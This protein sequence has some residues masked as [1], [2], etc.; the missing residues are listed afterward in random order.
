M[1]RIFVATAAVNTEHSPFELSD[2]LRVLRAAEHDVIKKHVCVTDPDDADFILFVGSR[3]QY[4]FDVLSSQIYQ[5]YRDRCFIFD[6]KDNP[7]PSLPGVYMGIP[8]YLQKCPAYRHGFYL[9]TFDNGVLR[10]C[11]SF[12]ECKYLFSFVGAVANSPSVRRE[13]LSLESKDGFVKDSSSHQCD[14]DGTYAK[15]LAESKFVICPRGKGPSTWRVFEA[16]RSGRSPV[17][18]SDEW[19]PPIGPRWLDF[20]VF[21]RECDV[22]QIPDRLRSLE[23]AAEEMGRTAYDEWSRNFS[24]SRAFNWIGDTLESIEQ[25][26]SSWRTTVKRSRLLEAVSRRIHGR[27]YLK[28]YVRQ[29]L[30]PNGR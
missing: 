4:H 16:M 20:A 27:Q 2:Y 14:V 3:Y 22:P 11:T 21:V 1:S 24:L 9:R 23:H 28:E 7:I 25:S 19:V 30:F 15:L 5:A 17:I 6:N 26:R 29:L 12:D 8:N 18:V 10:D 13:V